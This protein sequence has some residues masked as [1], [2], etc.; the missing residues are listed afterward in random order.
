MS[1]LLADDDAQLATFLSKS[2]ESEGHSVHIAGDADAFRAEL[3][4]Q[5]YNLIIL[6]LNFGNT[7]GLHLL[8]KLRADGL[9]TPVIVLSARN[10]VSDRIQ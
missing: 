8:E 10:Q 4:R 9:K 6:D 3:G 2:L 1:I 5:N 7:D